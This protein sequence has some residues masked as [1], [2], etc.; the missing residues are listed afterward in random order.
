MWGV[1]GG[2][3][4]FMPGDFMG[5]IWPLTITRN[6]DYFILEFRKLSVPSQIIITEGFSYNIGLK[7]KHALIILF[8]IFMS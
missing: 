8:H 3:G 5:E 1:G 7:N 2:G 6:I 4:A